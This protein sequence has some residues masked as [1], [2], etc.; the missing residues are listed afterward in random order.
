MF[1]NIR[2]F[3]ANTYYLSIFP[4][5]YAEALQTFVN[6]SFEL[7]H[8]YVNGDGIVYTRTHPF[9]SPVRGRTSAVDLRAGDLL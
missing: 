9:Y 6:E 8:I 2:K 5:K 7:V 1:F 3:R 4:V